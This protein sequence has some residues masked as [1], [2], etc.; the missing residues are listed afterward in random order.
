VWPQWRAVWREAGST[1]AEFFRKALPVFFAISAVAS[2]LAWAG[3]L[4]AAAGW[5]SPAMA[6]LALPPDAA[7]PVIL[8]GIRKD[9]I[10]LLAEDGLAGSMTSAQILASVFLAGTLMPCLVTALTVGRELGLRF[11]GALVARQALM[12]IAVSLLIAWGGIAVAGWWS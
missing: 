11:T 5:V 2:L 8:A 6:L 10:L 4:D 9:G 3:V 7:L 12:S 1:I